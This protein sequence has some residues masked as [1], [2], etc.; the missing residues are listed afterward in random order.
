[1]ANSMHIQL[2]NMHKKVDQTCATS[3][4]RHSYIDKIEWL[5]NN[6]ITLIKHLIKVNKQ[7]E[8]QST[9]NK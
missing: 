4:N 5:Y 3:R 7:L 1:M 9:F 8:V 6:V 2:V